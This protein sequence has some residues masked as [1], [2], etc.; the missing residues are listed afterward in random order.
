M[1]MPLFEWHA[2]QSKKNPTS[3]SHVELGLV[4]PLVALG[5]TTQI[6]A[7]QRLYH[8]NTKLN[9]IYILFCAV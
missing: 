8:K 9:S 3:T 5:N 1:N 2:G 4:S 7:L 6:R